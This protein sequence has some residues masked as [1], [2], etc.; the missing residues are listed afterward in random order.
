[1]SDALD[2]ARADLVDGRAWKARDRLT[3][4]LTRIDDEVLN[5]L[6]Q[7]N[8]EMGDLSAAGGLWFVTGR[9]DERS[10]EAVAAWRERHGNAQARRRS[11]PRPVR[12]TPPSPQVRELRR[13][14]MEHPTTGADGLDAA[15]KASC[16]GCSL[17]AATM[18]VL[19][20]VLATIG[21]VTV[22]NSLTG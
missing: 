12:T 1:M 6:A 7:A 15:E 20:V 17:L 9:N 4:L 8:C 21:G 2:R 13:A 22:V 19:V 3:G 16:S 10:R 5:L 11:L 18:V 14:A